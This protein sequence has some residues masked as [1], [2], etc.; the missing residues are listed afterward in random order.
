[1]DPSSSENS[2]STVLSQLQG[3][4][5][6]DAQARAELERVLSS[7]LFR[8]AEGLKRFLRY[9]V[10][11]TL[12]GQGDQLKEYRLAVDVFDRDSSF[13]PRLDPV[14]RMAARRL[15]G[16]LHDYYEQEG[17]F[18]PV[19]IAMPK[20]AYA[21]VFSMN[22]R[23]RVLSAAPG[24]RHSSESAPLLHRFWGPATVII[25]VAVAAGV[26][27]WLGAG[28]VPHI[29][30]QPILAN[31]DYVL[32]SDFANSTGD[33]VFDDTLKQAVSVQ[34]QQ[35]PVV[36][37][38]SPTRIA[39]TLKLMSRPIDSRLTPDLARDVCERAGAKADIAGS[40]TRLGSQFVIELQAT[41]CHN[42]DVFAQQLATAE[43]KEQVLKALDDAATRIRERLGESLSTVERFD[44]PL[45]QA[46]TPSLDALKAFSLGNLARDRK[47]DGAAIPFF[48]HAIDLDGN[49]ALAYSALGLTYSNLDEPALA[50]ANIAKA[51]ELRN[52]VSEREQ[53]EIATNYSQIVTGDLRQ[54][55]ETAALWAQAYPRDE[56]PHNIL[57]VNYEFLGQYQSAVA[58]MTEAVR[59]NPEG[60]ILHSNLMEEYTALDRLEEAK[61]TYRIALEHK[62]EH[63]YLHANK[64]GIAFLEGDVAEM[65]RQVAWV[66]G[67]KG[68]EDFLLSIQSDSKAYFGKLTEAR[69]DSQ[70]AVESARAGGQKETAALW[71]ANAALREAEFGNLERAR[72]DADAALALAATRDVKTLAALV[73][74]R[75]G[76]IKRAQMI[77]DE[78]AR[79]FPLNTVINGYWL[80]TISAAIELSR[81]N[82]AAA[83]EVLRSSIPYELGYPNPQVEVGRFLYPPY[84]RG[85]AYLALD[86]GSEAASEFQKIVDHRSLLENCPLRALAHLG[87]ARA[88][89]LGFETNN[90][91][92]AFQD[93]FTL[94]KSADPGIPILKQARAEYARLH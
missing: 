38:L 60:V 24:N 55:N 19:R 74:A 83:L 73:F 43:N 6:A 29:R 12:Q 18:D 76:E 67:Q 10:D 61:A 25:A 51:Y 5:P 46:T 65:N 79:S 40:I 17:Q 77:R 50:A 91:R 49:F 11:H 57:G 72:K 59:L 94:W 53:F 93:F 26:L 33:S 89:R 22:A 9:T 63:P 4:Y 36:N 8:D 69:E 39:A 48:R 71:Q 70:H 58:E 41:S 62:L 21:V 2:S 52:R 92:S 16:K 7:A 90:S 14:D 88:Y 13:D 54:A 64:Y 27:A 20:G 68:A 34:L 28:L 78:V 82:P 85:Q 44:T 42:G 86:R 35:S 1:V 66:T 75:A 3:D 23:A 37:I 84:L 31:T 56:Y 45:E 30:S 81:S 32:I 47:G 15:R 80:P 87:L